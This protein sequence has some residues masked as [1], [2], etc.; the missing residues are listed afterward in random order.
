MKEIKTFEVIKKLYSKDP[1]ISESFVG[2]PYY[3]IACV[4]FGLV[5][6]I[7]PMRP[8]CLQIE[9]HQSEKKPF[10]YMDNLFKYEAVDL[11]DGYVGY[12]YSDDDSEFYGIVTEMNGYVVIASPTEYTKKMTYEEDDTVEYRK[13]YQPTVA[14]RKDVWDSYTPV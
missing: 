6:A 12:K 1:D 3:T 5:G 4:Y 9:P 10:L 11:G 8:V 2:A 14:I 7:S 13:V